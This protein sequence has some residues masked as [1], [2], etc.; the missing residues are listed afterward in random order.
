M[1]DYRKVSVIIGIISTVVSLVGVSIMFFSET[2]CLTMGIIII[3]LALAGGLI[4]LDLFSII[5][6]VLGGCMCVFSPVI[7]GIITIC[8]G[9]I[10][11][12]VNV[13][14]YRKRTKLG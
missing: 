11:A 9:A 14:I 7:A 13:I 12:V 2:T 5:Y 1:K 6:L 10:L 4:T 3:C 8:F